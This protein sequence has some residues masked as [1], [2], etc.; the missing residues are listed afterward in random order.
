[1]AAKQIPA[2]K[3]RKFKTAVMLTES[4]DSAI[5]SIAESTLR[6]KSW[7]ISQAVKLYLRN[8]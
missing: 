7:V 3:R 6:S 4:E 8:H 5:D 2:E 1:M